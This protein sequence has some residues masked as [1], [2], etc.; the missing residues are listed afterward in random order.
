MEHGNVMVV[1]GRR[2][3]LTTDGGTCM[4]LEGHHNYSWLPLANFV[5]VFL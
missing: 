2:K 5:L 1:S 3:E 4:N